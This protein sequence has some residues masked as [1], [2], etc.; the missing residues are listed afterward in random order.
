M[1]DAGPMCTEWYIKNWNKK[2]FTLI[3]IRLYP[4]DVSNTIGRGIGI[5]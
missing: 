4:P 3:A 2:G 5:G 1:E